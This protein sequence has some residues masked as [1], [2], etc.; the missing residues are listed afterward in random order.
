VKFAESPDAQDPGTKRRNSGNPAC[1]RAK[2]HLKEETLSKH[3]V[4]E[5]EFARTAKDAR[6][7][8]PIWNSLYQFKLY[9]YSHRAL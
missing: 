5:I 6:G 3:H 4:P 2:L 8:M 9:S 1:L 7:L